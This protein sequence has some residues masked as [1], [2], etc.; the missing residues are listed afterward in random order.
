MKKYFALL[1]VVVLWNCSSNDDD[2]PVILP[3]Q[4][5][6]NVSYGPDSQQVIDIH[7]PEGRIS[8]T[9]KTL[10]LL[11]GG[12]WYGGSKEDMAAAVALTRLQFP[13]YAIVN[14]EYRLATA[15][16]PAYPKQINDLEA[17]I[18]HLETHPYGLSKQYAFIGVS[19]GAHLS[20]LYAYHFDP[21]HH[22]KAVCSIVGPTDFT[23]P[24]Y[25]GSE[26]E[27]ALFPFLVGA[28]PSQELVQEVSPASHIDASDPP[29]IQFL[30]SEDPLVPTSQG[31]RL[32]AQLDLAGITNS[33]HVYQAGHG[34]FSI[35]DSQ[36]IYAKIGNF[37]NA[38]F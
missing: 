13:S 38:N 29:T 11:H 31:I 3:A 23:D 16:S 33:M 35:T 37:L 6:S 32:K 18:E 24:A 17:V 34:N 27:H 26:L 20:M 25:A 2:Q 7:L 15:E 12:A 28:N 1:F 19:A 10:L 4:T 36:E 22:V 5:F 9:T 14:V 8:G 21:E 30:G